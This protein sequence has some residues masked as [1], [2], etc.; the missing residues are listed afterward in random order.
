M[1]PPGFDLLLSTGVD[2]PDDDE[3]NAYYRIERD[4]AASIISNRSKRIFSL[5]LQDG[6]RISGGINQQGVLFGDRI[7]PMPEGTLR[8]YPLRWYEHPNGN[9]VERES[10]SG[11]EETTPM[12]VP[13][14]RSK[15]VAARK[16]PDPD[17]LSAL[18]EAATAVEEYHARQTQLEAENAE[19]RA[20]ID[21]LTARVNGIDIAK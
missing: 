19:L 20:R 15:P 16:S 1:L 8:R 6:S 4:G 12:G 14:V 2:D 3:N 13:K 10:Q 11:T 18:R 21:A 9:S 5:P 17:T 7:V